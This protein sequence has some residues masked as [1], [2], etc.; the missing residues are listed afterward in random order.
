V[1]KKIMTSIVLGALLAASG[2][3]FA[4]TGAK[5]LADR[6]ALRENFPQYKGKVDLR[7]ALGNVTFYY[8]GGDRCPTGAQPTDRQIDILLAAHLQGHDVALDYTDINTVTYGISHCWD[9][10]L[11]VF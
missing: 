7:D 10:N 6:I 11:Q 8:W 3:A 5:G 1:T 2:T 9:G 4:T